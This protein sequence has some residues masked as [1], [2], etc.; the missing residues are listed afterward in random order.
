[1]AS[2]SKFD[3]GLLAGGVT[4]PGPPDLGPLSLG[5]DATLG[6]LAFAQEFRRQVIAMTD[7]E[8]GTRLGEDPEELHDMRVATR[9]RAALD[10]FIEVLPA[11]PAPARGRWDGSLRCS[12]RSATSTCS[13]DASPRWSGGC[14]SGRSR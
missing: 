1:M 7:H 8:P 13:S 3:A 14:P 2:L 9:L 10:L 6:E 12:E 5:P 4:L 11:R